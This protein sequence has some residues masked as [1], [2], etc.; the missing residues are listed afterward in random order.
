M[1][2]RPVWWPQAENPQCDLGTGELRQRP[3]R[4]GSGV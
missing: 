2:L 3:A 1:R 4:S